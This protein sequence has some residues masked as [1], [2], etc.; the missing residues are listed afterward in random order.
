MDK[1][2][3]IKTASKIVEISKQLEVFTLDDLINN[4]PNTLNQKI[5]NRCIEWLIESADI[6]ILSGIISYK[7]THV[8]HS[9][10]NH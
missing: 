5:V 7:T 4:L 6:E 1:K 3:L 10:S 9:P 2:M 8:K